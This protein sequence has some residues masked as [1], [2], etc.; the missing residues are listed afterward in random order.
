MTYKQAAE[1]LMELAYWY[2]KK[3]QDSKGVRFS[4]SFVFND[5]GQDLSIDDLRSTVE[6]SAGYD[7]V[8]VIVSTQCEGLA[9]VLFDAVD[10]V[11]GLRYRISWTGEFSID[12][13][14]VHVYSVSSRMLS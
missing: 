5:N 14:L 12:G 4:M 3:R 8:E 1:N 6:I 13:T 10:I 9:V 11:T 7:P 2:S